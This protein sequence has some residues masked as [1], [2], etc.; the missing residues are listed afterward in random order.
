ME[1]HVYPP[2]NMCQ[3]HR[4]KKEPESEHEEENQGPKCSYCEESAA[5]QNK[6]RCA[7]H[8][9]HCVKKK[10]TRDQFES[11][12]YCEKHLV[13]TNGGRATWK[14]IMDVEKESLKRKI[15]ELEKDNNNNNN[16]DKDEEE[17]CSICME[18]EREV[19]I[20]PCLH[21]ATC[22][23]CTWKLPVKKCPICRGSID[24]FM[25]N[26]FV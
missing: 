5:G 26:K 10:C 14:R 22:Y 11:E 18:E 20:L 15:A 2:I 24:G 3:M 16:K 23:E 19:T 9:L 12:I 6:G 8:Q 13:Q 7:R 1:S 17:G 25:R 21:C 4:V